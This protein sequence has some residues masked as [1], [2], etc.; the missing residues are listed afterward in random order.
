VLLIKMSI[1]SVVTAI[2]EDNTLCGFTDG[3]SGPEVFGT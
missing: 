2:S 3:E 1:W